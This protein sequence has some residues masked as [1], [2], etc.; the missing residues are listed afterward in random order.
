MQLHNP[1]GASIDLASPGAIGGTTPA[2]GTFT[3]LSVAQGTL[4]D[5]ATGLNLTATWNDAADTFRGVDI[6]I[7]DTNSASGS[8]PLRVMGGAAG[9]TALMSVNKTGRI[10]ATDLLLAAGSFTATGLGIGAGFIYSGSGLLAGRTNGLLLSLNSKI[11]FSSGSYLD[12]TMDTVL[13]RLAA[14]ALGVTDGAGGW[15]SL[16]LGTTSD[17]IRVGTHSAIGAETVTGYITVKDSGGTERKIA[18]VS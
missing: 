11:Q 16:R 18:V 13:E 7:T 4:T 15:G 10:T 14:G 6:T 12:G 3:G 5:P 1:G 2:A 9:T 8:T 17:A